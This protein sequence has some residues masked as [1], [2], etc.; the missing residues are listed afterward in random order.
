MITL[1]NGCFA[2]GSNDSTI[3]IWERK[4]ENW[5]CI[6]TLR[7]HTDTVLSLT[8]LSYNQIAS[9]S[10]D[11]TIRIWQGVG[12]SWRCVTVLDIAKYDL[13]PKKRTLH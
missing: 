8:I 9:S 1:S 6:A 12:S 2:S 3:K 4:N 13:A 10:S 11:K 7:G 5:I